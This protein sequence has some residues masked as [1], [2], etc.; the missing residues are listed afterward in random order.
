MQSHIN[1]DGLSSDELLALLSGDFRP[2]RA[3]S[4]VAPESET[5]KRINVAFLRR[6]SHGTVRPETQF[7]RTTPALVMSG[8]CSIEEVTLRTRR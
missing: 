2:S 4:A 1:I 8:G 3:F 7:T 5:S 6:I